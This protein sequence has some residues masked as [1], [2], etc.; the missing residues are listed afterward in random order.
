MI[1]LVGFWNPGKHEVIGY[2]G[3]ERKLVVGGMLS[4]RGPCR[5]LS[6]VYQLK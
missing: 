2:V 4:E 1:G 6:V 3:N 5:V